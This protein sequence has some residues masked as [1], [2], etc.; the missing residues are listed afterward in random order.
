MWDYF[1]RNWNAQNPG[2]WIFIC[3]W[4]SQLYTLGS[5]SSMLLLTPIEMI[6]KYQRTQAE[7]KISETIFTQKQCGSQKTP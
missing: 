2:A 6:L 5:Q 4:E 3:F 1:E 7:I